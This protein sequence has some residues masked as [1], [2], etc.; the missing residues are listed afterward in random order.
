MQVKTIIKKYCYC[1][2]QERENNISIAKEGNT[3]L[4]TIA[5]HFKY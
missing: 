4:K 2:R 1:E 5:T 3:Y